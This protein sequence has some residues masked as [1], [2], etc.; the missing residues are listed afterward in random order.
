MSL[1]GTR[2]GPYEVLGL[3]GAGGMGEVYRAR[4]TRLDRTVAIKIL[5][6]ADP[7][8]KARFTREAKAIAALTHPHICTLYDVGHDERTDYLVMEYLDGET[9]AA[10]LSRGPLTLNT[11]F[12]VATHI[13]EALDE[14]HRAGIVHRDLKPGNVIVRPDGTAKVLDFGLAR[15]TRPG[16]ELAGDATTRQTL[17]IPGTLMGTPHYMSPEQVRGETADA[18]T[19]LWSLGVILY[20][21]L[22][23]QRPFEGGSPAEILSA[24]IAREP[25]PLSSLN[26][27]VP[28]D[29]APVVAGLLSKDRHQ[30]RNSAAAVAQELKRLAESVAARPARAR[31]QRV[32]AA[33]AIVILVLF[34]AGVWWAYGV[35]KRQWARYEAVPLARTLAD[36][37]DYTGA[38]RVALDAA[39]YI[40]RKDALLHLWPDVSQLLSVRSDPPGAEVVWK[41]Y[42]QM[43]APWESLGRTPLENARVPMGAVRVQLRMGGYEPVEVAV[44]RVTSVGAIPASTYEFRLHQSGSTQAHMVSVPA[45]PGGSTLSGVRRSMEPFEIDRYE[46]T[47]REFKTFVDAGGYRN[48]QYWTVAFVQDGQHRSWEEAMSQFVD[49]T[50][51]P[52][53]ATWEAGSYSPGQD[54][55]PVSGVSWYEAAAYAAFVGKSL[56]TIDHWLRASNLDAVASD[57]RFL[58]GLSNLAAAHPQRVGASGAV[59][60]VGLY[61]VVGNVREWA[62]NEIGGRRHILGGGWTDKAEGLAGND[63]L[64]PFDRSI[65]N[66]FRCVR[67]ADPVRALQEFGGPR[68]VER[69]PDYYKIKPVSDEV[70][71]LYK[72]LYAYDRKPLKPVVESVVE[73]SDLWRR[74]KVRFK[75]PYGD[76]DVVA[77]L[78]LPKQAKPPYQTVVYM[79]DGGT[80]RPGSGE[81]IEPEQFILRSGRAMLYPIYKGTLD[82]YVK[83]APGP[84]ALRDMT[85]T[86][87]KD[88]GSSVDYLETRADIDATRLAY[89]GHSMG[90]RFAPMMLATVPRFR[91]A[92]LLAGAMR[93]VGALP[94]ADPVNFLPR[95]TIPILHVTGRYDAGYPV[96][97][98]QKPFFDLFG[99]PPQDKRHLVLPVGHAILVP[100]VRT[101]VIREVLDWLDRYLGKP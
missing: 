21:A 31:R 45:T 91:T 62:W 42:A 58:V 97:V 51:R 82:R 63:N 46:V 52:G 48:P 5:S 77:Y 56:P 44:D 4:D 26:R 85:I 13:A 2:L 96:D 47:N 70:F 37:G 10:R 8:L 100:E 12:T 90:T 75:A 36:R 94:E 27:D 35:S 73:A 20:E 39:R 3:I 78:F 16:G 66:G 68:S 17:T 98:A 87:S 61:D 18:T 55:Y 11:A 69:F 25:S 71:D 57:L 43:G 92:I 50:R 88:L 65:V 80:L 33:A 19:D 95:V 24:I 15:L 7:D 86:W 38:Y 32:V 74:E 30:R 79:A 9:L 34:A 23:G 81:T 84:L 59:N 28:P 49:P 99:T 29:A 64:D 83:I 40:P 76:E 6:S 22:T 67:Y 89:M 101:T 14:A 53:P 72:G 41:P 93:P 54:D 1:A 60:T